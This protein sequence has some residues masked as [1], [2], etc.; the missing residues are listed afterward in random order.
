MTSKTV[1]NYIKKHYYEET[2]EEI[3]GKFD[4]HPSSVR[5]IAKENDITKR[6]RI[7]ITKSYKPIPGFSRYKISESGTI[8]RA[9]DSVLI[10]SQINQ[11]GYHNVKLVNDEGV[12]KTV[13]VHRMVAI[14]YIPNPDSLPEV[15]HLNG[16]DDNHYKSLEWSSPSN[17]V[18]HSYATGLRPRTKGADSA[19]AK[20]SE[21]T[22][23]QIC[24]LI[25]DGYRNKDIVEMIPG[26]NKSLVKCLKRKVRWTHITSLYNI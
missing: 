17:N 23:H 16:K 4:L 13:R 19:R 25:E 9:K 15:N 8:I 24:K 18:L 26:I 20:Y 12:R 3:A 6:I 1:L 2:A 10:Q 21:D 14:T 7:A 5:R 11:E 22:I